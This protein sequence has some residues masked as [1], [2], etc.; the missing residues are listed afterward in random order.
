M[1]TLYLPSLQNQSAKPGVTPERRLLSTVTPRLAECSNREPPLLL[2]LFNSLFA[3]TTWVSRHQKGNHSGFYWS[4][5]RWGGSGISWATGKSF[6]PRSRQITTPVPHHSVFTGRMPF[7]P[8]HQQHQST[9]GKLWGKLSPAVH[10]W[11]SDLRHNQQRQS[12]DGHSQR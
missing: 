3:R 10:G 4:K 2:H 12:T 8:P 11:M 6:A 5:R 9:K 1:V 7:L